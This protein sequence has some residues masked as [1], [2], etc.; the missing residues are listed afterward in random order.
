MNDYIIKDFLNSFFAFFNAYIEGFRIQDNKIFGTLGWVGEEDKQDF[1]WSI[2]FDD[3]MLLKLKLLCDFLQEHSLIE[4]DKILISE[5]ELKK[6]LAKLNWNLQEADEQINN[7]CN[8]E[9]KMIDDGEE[10]DSFFIHF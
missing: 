2:V 3:S 8:I 1:S 7:L 5:T 4:G 6:Q 9:I 10:T